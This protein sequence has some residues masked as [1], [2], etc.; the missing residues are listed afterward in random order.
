MCVTRVGVIFL[1]SLLLIE[2]VISSQHHPC[3]A[4][5]RTMWQPQRVFVCSFFSGWM[6][7]HAGRIVHRRCYLVLDVGLR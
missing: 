3:S 5:P 4:V 1:L 6:E 7:C 2:F